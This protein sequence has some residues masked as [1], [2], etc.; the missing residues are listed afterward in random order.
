[1]KRADRLAAQAAFL[2]AFAASGVV[3]IGC[4][5]ANINRTLVD[6]WNE[7]DERFN[8]AYGQARREAD[9]RIRAEIQ[10]RAVQGI[11][12]RRTVM[13]NGTTERVEEIQDY[14]DQLLMFLAKSRMPEFK[15]REIVRL[16]ID[17]EALRF[18]VDIITRNVTDEDTLGRI[19]AELAQFATAESPA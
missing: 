4:R 14:S 19:R 11:T 8:V 2:S 7:H 16:V 3:L 6:Y 18:I 1:M 9:D 15:D 12:K 13:I 10:R 17:E 5:S